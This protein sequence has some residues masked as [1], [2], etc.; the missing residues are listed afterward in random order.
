VSPAVVLAVAVALAAL[1]H[2]PSAPAAVPKTAA[3]LVVGL[4]LVA[5]RLPVALR[6]RS[7]TLSGGAAGWLLL[8]AWALTTLAWADHPLL[9]DLSLWLAGGAVAVYA[10]QLEQEPG[11]AAARGA[12]VLIGLGSAGAVAVQ[13]ATGA[14]GIGLHGLHGNP[15]WLGLVLAATLPLQLEALARPGG[16]RAPR[17][18]LGALSVVASVPALLLSG[19]RV[20]WL[21]LA[22]VAVVTGRGKIRY[23]VVGGAALALLHGWLAGDLS[24]SLAGRGWLWRS[25]LA[26]AAR[27]LPLGHG[28]GDFSHAF[29]HAQGVRL[30]RMAPEE[31]VAT[32]ENATTAHQDWLQLACE[33]GPVAALLL[34]AVLGLAFVKLR[35]RWPAGA[36]TVLAVAICGL[37]DAPLRQP[38]VVAVVCL[39]LGA[40]PRLPARRLDGVVAVATLIGVVVVL[41]SATARWLGARQLTA[42]RDLPLPDRLAQLRRAVAMDPRSGQ[43]ALALGLALLEGGDPRGALAELER[44]RERLAN[45][46]TEVAIGNAQLALGAP[47]PAIAAYRRALA[48]H[49]ALFRGHANLAEAYRV[50]GDLDRAATHLALARELLPN[51]PKLVR[52]AEQLRRDR[53]DAATR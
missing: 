6:A 4:S 5:L 49:P 12:A 38:A 11:Q 31:A 48:L 2:D 34:L 50:K 15:N 21:A 46:G 53:I 30:G 32:F 39:V 47:E 17:W 10:S 18:W 33:G 51:H 35:H 8:C 22:V 29:L 23:L 26:A 25:S 40:T 16:R 36:A 37:G 43:A 27:G 7:L 24:R 42:A 52:L 1:V 41:P 13:A 9:G 45:V 3:L 44:S 20:A 19:S 14:R 28:M